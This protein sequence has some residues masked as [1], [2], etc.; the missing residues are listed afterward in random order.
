MRPP[1]FAPPSA[2]HFLGGGYGQ[3]A[4]SA[5]GG[6]PYVSYTRVK[7]PSGAETIVPVCKDPYCTGCSLSMPG[8]MANA[9]AFAAAAGFPGFMPPGAGG[10]G[11]GG[12]CPAGCVQ[13]DH[14]KFSIGQFPG[15]MPHPGMAGLLP[16]TSSAG[17]PASL[18]SQHVQAQQQQQ[19]QQ[20]QA[21]AAQQQQQNSQ[22]PYVCNWIV[23]ESYCGKRF[24]SSEELLQHLR[25]HTNLSTSEASPSSLY[26]SALLSSQMSAAAAAMHRTYPTPPLS[27][28]SAARYNP[29]GG[30][31]PGAFGGIPTS[32]SSLVPHPQSLANYYS[33]MSPYALYGQRIGPPVHP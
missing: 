7:T 6:S 27:P 31:K 16:P 3:S 22:R 2:H 32:L 8:L 13:C 18:M 10:G 17:Y 28:L 5:S 23:A 19:Q 15:F 21:A 29:F 4:L 14:Q 12:I 26:S 25:T 9:A 20:A 1:F 24:P 11:S 30:G 33:S